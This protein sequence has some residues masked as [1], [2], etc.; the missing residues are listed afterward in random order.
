MKITSYFAVVAL[1]ASDSVVGVLAKGIET[2]MRAPDV[3][4]KMVAQGFEPIGNSPVEFAK[5]V[6][7]EIP[8]WEKVVNNAGIKG[9]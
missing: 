9:E 1:G 3:R 5:C 6:R 4:D 2:S 7:E 8:R